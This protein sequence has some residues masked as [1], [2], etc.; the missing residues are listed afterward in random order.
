MDIRESMSVS[1]DLTYPLPIVKE[2]GFPDNRDTVYRPTSGTLRSLKRL[3]EEDLPETVVDKKVL[4]VRLFNS[5]IL[6]DKFFACTNSM[7]RAGGIAR[8]VL[9]LL[10]KLDVV[11]QR[12]GMHLAPRNPFP[13][14]F[15]G[16]FLLVE[17]TQRSVYHYEFSCLNR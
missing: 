7:T 11:R 16:V 12:L 6:C 15:S 10:H 5:E 4:N 1:G 17:L 9:S 2:F 3:T 8:R 14:V 13:S